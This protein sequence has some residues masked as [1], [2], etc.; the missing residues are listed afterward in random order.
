MLASTATP[1]DVID[2]LHVFVLVVVASIAFEWCF[3][4]GRFASSR[5]IG[6]PWLFVHPT[7]GVY[8]AP[9]S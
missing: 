9:R 7:S 1:K 2:T 5:P 6:S 3:L 8:L 4:P